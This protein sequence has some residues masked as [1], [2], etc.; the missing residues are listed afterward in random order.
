MIVVKLG[1]SLVREGCNSSIYEEIARAS[2]M[3]GLVLV[4]GGGDEV[5]EIAK[6]LGHEQKFVISESGIESRYTDWET[7]KIYAMVMSGLI[8]KRIE[9]NLI[10]YNVRP[11]CITG[12]D[13]LMLI[14]ERK[15][16][17]LI[18]QGDRKFFIDGGYT[19][20]I[21]KVDP[22]PLFVLIEL[23]FLPII[24]PIALSE[25][26][27][28]LNVDSDRVASHIASSL[29]A[30]S[31]I[32]LTDVDGVYL[33]NELIEKLSQ[34]DCEKLISE[35]GQGMKMK[36]IASMHALKNGVKKVIIAN[37]NADD[38]NLVNPE[39]MKRKTIICDEL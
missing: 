35:V 34:K 31:L 6:R 25:E 18:K 14:A 13:G 24:S 32:L 27:E 9:L 3:K 2:K 28:M 11:F 33:R 12:L 38:L 29:N 36:L 1:G 37:G 19:G 5:T 17:L 7:M 8:A 10:K 4:H 30:E 15:K 26:G 16:R 21:K 20:M 23:G 22:Y 39:E